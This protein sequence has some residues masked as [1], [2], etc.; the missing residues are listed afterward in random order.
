MLLAA[1][2]AGGGIDGQ[3]LRV[4]S[5]QTVVCDGIERGPGLD[6]LRVDKFQERSPRAGGVTRRGEPSPAVGLRRIAFSKPVRERGRVMRCIAGPMASGRDSRDATA[7]PGWQ[8]TKERNMPADHVDVV[9]VHG[10][11]ADR[12]SWFLIAEDD[13]VIA[14]GTQRLTAGRMGARTRPADHTPPV[15]APADGADIVPD[16]VRDAATAT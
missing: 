8:G 1:D 2:K 3:Q 9:L 5:G 16:A 15:T 12:S 6:V 13:R 7:H 10:A 11:R 4:E 14:P